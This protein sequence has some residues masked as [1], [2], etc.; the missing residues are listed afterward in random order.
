MIYLC[1]FEDSFTYNIYSILKTYNPDIEIEVI[2][3]NRVLTFLQK[4]KFSEQKH[5][6][7][8]GPGPGHPEDYQYLMSTIYGLLQNKNVFF[9]GICLGHQL[10]WSSVG[11]TIEHCHLPVH[12]Q[13][14]SYNLPKQFQKDL[15]LNESIIHV[16]HY[17]SLAV[18]EHSRLDQALPGVNRYSLNDE[19]LISYGE[20]L[21]TYQFHPESIG[22]TFPQM[23]FRSID[24]FLL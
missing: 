9:L 21:V 18:K 14:R 24:Q 7:I 10:I 3:K 4:T 20:R 13:T 16:Q 17:N 2:Q 23:F 11:A 8:L 19:I 12:G 6:I 1:D 15:N 22:T 5:V